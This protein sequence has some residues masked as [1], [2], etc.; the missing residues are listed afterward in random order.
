MGRARRRS[1]GQRDATVLEADSASAAAGVIG[2][3][4]FSQRISIPALAEA[5]FTLSIVA[6]ATGVTA[7]GAAYRFGF[8]RAGTLED[9]LVSDDLHVIWIALDTIRMRTS[10]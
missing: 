8:I 6:S 3:G 10:P 2:S 7:A 4:S 5:G 1:H 9:V